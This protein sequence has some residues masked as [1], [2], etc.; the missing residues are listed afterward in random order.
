[1]YNNPLPKKTVA[2]NW[3]SNS[4]RRLRTT[5]INHREA[6]PANGSRFKAALSALPSGLRN[7]L[8][9]EYQTIVQNWLEQRWLPSE[10]YG[11]RF[12]EIVYTVLDGHAKSKYAAKPANF[13]DACKKLENNSHVPR[14][15]QILIPRIHLRKCEFLWCGPMAVGSSRVLRPELKLHRTDSYSGFCITS[16]ELMEWIEEDD[17]GY[18]VR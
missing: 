5:P 9:T 11:G 2:K 3:S 8:L 7:P 14:S 15:F 18:F 4:P 12:S 17:K 16:K 10:L 6:I 1:M 13:A